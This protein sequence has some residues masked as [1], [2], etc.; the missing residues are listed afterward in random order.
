MKRDSRLSRALHVILHLAECE[1]PM[2]STTLAKIVGTNAV[3]VR[4]TLA[5]LRER[6]LVASARGH[7]GGWTLTCD[8]GETS[9]R[10]VHAALGAPRCIALSRPGEDSSCLVEQAVNRALGEAF[11]EAEA[12]L[13][14]RFEEVSLA[15]LSAD[16]GERL[17]EH[18]EAIERIRKP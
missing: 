16:F 4:R 1:A 2:T 6:G 18:F 17:A 15:S 13:L 14:A 8:L 9:L 11:D 5:G 12:L 7:G 10:D 3:V